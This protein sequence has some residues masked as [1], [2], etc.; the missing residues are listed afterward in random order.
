MRGG[1]LSETP[2]TK[3]GLKD[4]K[5]VARHSVSAET[6][7]KNM[8]IQAVTYRAEMDAGP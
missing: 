3:T 5:K 7:L 6:H 8:S 4:K 1:V 2:N